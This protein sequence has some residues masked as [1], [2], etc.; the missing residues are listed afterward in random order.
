MSPK[1]KVLLFTATA[2]AATAPT[3]LYRRSSSFSSAST[4][5][6]GTR[7]DGVASTIHKV[8]LQDAANAIGVK[9]RQTTW[10][11]SVAK[12]LGESYNPSIR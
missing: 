10:E 8:E 7:V 12:V 5:T 6:T 2:L 3:K 9:T 11:D 4:G 1:T